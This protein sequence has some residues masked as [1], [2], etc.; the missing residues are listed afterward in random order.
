MC[1]WKFSQNRIMPRRLEVF[2]GEVEDR[3]QQRSRVQHVKIERREL[4]AEMQFR[5]VIERTAAVGAQPLVDRPTNH[6]AH[7]IKIKMQIERDIVIEA[8]AFIVNRVATDEAKTKRNNFSRLSPDEKTRPL[9]HGLRDST[10]KFLRQ[11][12][13]FHWRALVHLEIERI[14]RVNVRRDI[15]N[16][17]HINLSRA[18]RLSELSTQALAA[19]VTERLQ[20][21]VEVLKWQL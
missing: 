21:F 8:K 4:V 13:E 18:L 5:I 10:K 15:V 16:D 3:I 17:F 14:N 19:D 1:V 9:R 12:F 6:V 20:I 2:H 7:R 11:R